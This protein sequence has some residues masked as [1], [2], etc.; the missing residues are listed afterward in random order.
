MKKIILIL[1]LACVLVCIFTIT[2]FAAS[3]DEF[4][5]IEF[6]DGISE[7][8]AFGADGKADTCTS[9]VVLF[10]GTEYHTYPS[11]YIFTNTTN[12]SSL[13]FDAINAASG[14]VYEKSSLIRVEVPKNILK[15][16]STLRDS[17]NLVYIY[18]PETIVEMGRDGFH[19]CTAL[20]Y[21]NVPR[22]CKEI[23]HYCLNNCGSLEVLDMSEAKSLKSILSH[24]L[25]GSQLTSLIFPEGFENF[26]GISSSTLKVIKFPNS[27]KSVG[28]LQCSGLEEIVLPA[29]LTT[30]GNKTL[31]YCGSLKKV[32]LPKSLTSIVLGN[33]PSFFGTTLSN[34]KEIYYTGKP[35][36]AILNDIKTAVPKAEIIFVNHCDVYYNGEHFEDNNPCVINCEQCGAVNEPEKN[37]EHME[38][39]T[40]V[41]ASFDSVGSKDVCCTNEGCQFIEST[42]SSPLFVCLGYSV[43]KGDIGGISLGYKIDKAAID[44]YTAITDK[45]ISFGVFAAVRNVIGDNEAVLENGNMN[46][47]VLGLNLT[48]YANAVMQIKVTGFTNDVHKN[49]KIILGAFVVENSGDETK[50][51]YMQESEPNNGEKYAFVQFS[52]MN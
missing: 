43:Y 22:D 21:I 42:P 52:E 32:T 38:I 30:M 7:K 27:V 29:N 9:R 20:K 8:S 44:E 16:G 35:T 40:M 46:D 2:A 26:D 10:D 50:V 28:V 17:K 33:N 15:I 4:G 18:L 41:Y 51:F 6:V 47:N 3:T 34:L 48:S 14:I 31:D 45:S 5:T 37:P 24:N 39:V 19:G 13:T 23:G 1:T 36:D 49:A 11:Y 12:G 25:G